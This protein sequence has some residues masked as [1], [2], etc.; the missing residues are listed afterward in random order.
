[1]PSLDYTLVQSKMKRLIGWPS[2]SAGAIT[3]CMLLQKN[4][5][6]SPTPNKHCVHKLQPRRLIYPL[7][8][9]KIAQAQEDNAVL[10]K[11]CKTDKHSTQLVENT[12]FLCKD[13]KMGIPKVLQHSAVSMYHHYLQHPR[14]TC[15]EEKLCAAMYWK[16][17]RNTIQSHV[18]H[19]RICQVNKGH[20][21]KYGNL[22]AAKHVITNPWEAFYVV[23]TS[24][25]RTLSKVKMEHKLTVCSW[26]WLIQ[27]PA[28][29][30]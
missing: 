11:L 7:T 26:L 2:R 23:C 17:M 13:D 15:L 21:H 20:K 12:H 29:L 4:H 27:L 16:G 24:L 5:T 22:P 8:V 30:K 25:D 1:M 28:G 10:K 6:G 14:H 19:C 3:P 18:K 9:K